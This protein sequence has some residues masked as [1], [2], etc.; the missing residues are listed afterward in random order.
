MNPVKELKKASFFIAICFGMLTLSLG[1]TEQLI[2]KSW[3][4]KLKNV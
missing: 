4:I 3:A 1:V 2:R